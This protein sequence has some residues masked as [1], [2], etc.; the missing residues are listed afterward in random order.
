MPAVID[1]AK[2][3]IRGAEALDVP[4]IVTEQYPKALGNTVEELQGVLPQKSFVQDK[5]HFSMM[6]TSPPPR[7]S[8]VFCGC[9]QQKPLSSS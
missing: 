9:L 2:R 8:Y 6:G 1:T 5:F 3:M 7:S 4:V